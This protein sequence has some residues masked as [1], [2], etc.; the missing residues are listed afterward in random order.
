MHRMNS[1]NGEKRG[2]DDETP[3]DHYSK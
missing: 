3:I 2:D 1:E